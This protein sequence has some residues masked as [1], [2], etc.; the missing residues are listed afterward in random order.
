[1]NRL[2][3]YLKRP[4]PIYEYDDIFKGQKQQTWTDVNNIQFTL[5]QDFDSSFITFSVKFKFGISTCKYEVKE[6]NKEELKRIR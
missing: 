5:K 4:Y 3:Q 6:N 1:M 2:I